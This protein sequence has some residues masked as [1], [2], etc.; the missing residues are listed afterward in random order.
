MEGEEKMAASRSNG[1]YDAKTSLNGELVRAF[2]QYSVKFRHEKIVQCR[3]G[4]LPQQWG[5]SELHLETVGINC[6]LWY[7]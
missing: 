3:G 4:R 6:I 5:W 1:A 2:D 7:Y